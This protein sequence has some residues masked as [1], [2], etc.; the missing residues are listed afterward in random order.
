MG[1]KIHNLGIFWGT[2]FLLV[3]FFFG[4]FILPGIFWGIQNDGKICDKNLLWYK[5]LSFLSVLTV[6]NFSVEF[7]GGLI[8]VQEIF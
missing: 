4:S 7:F 2:I 1:F 5:R 6:L 8:L 3:F